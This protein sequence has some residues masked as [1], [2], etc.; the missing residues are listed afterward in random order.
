MNT[1]VVVADTQAPTTPSTLTATPLNPTQINLAWIAST[2]NVGVAGYL[3][4]RCQGA[5]CATFTQIAGPIVVVTYIDTGV[6]GG[7]SYSYRVRAVDS[8]GDLSSYSTVASATTPASD[9]QP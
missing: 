2:D 8:A 9:T 6:T 3:I 1:P 4:E 5:G 7:L